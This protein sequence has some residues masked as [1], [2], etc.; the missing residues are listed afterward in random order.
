MVRA[1]HAST[2]L[3]QLCQAKFIGSV[4]HY[5]IGAW[6]IDARFDDRCAQQY[7]EAL[8]VEVGHHALELTLDHL[9]VRDANTGLGYD[10]S[11]MGGRAFYGLYFVV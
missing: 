6:N 3:M 1:T 4:Y 11:Q 9:A 2:Q 5:R 8:V 10:F 7:I